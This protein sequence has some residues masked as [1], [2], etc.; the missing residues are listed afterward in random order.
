MQWSRLLAATN[1]VGGKLSWSIMTT[2][3]TNDAKEFMQVLSLAWC[4]HFP[5]LWLVWLCFQ[6]C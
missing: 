1:L 4:A 6:S 5:C 3:E 2:K